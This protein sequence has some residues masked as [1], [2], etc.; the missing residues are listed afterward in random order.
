[1]QVDPVERVRSASKR[2]AEPVES[3]TQTVARRATELVVDTVDVNALLDRTDLNR[4]LAQIDVNRLLDRV[5]V[6]RLIERLDI[7]ALLN[8]VDVNG[9]ADRIDVAALVD[10]TELGA[11]VATSSATVFSE[12]IDL[13]RSQAVGLDDF[14]GRLF[15]RLL[16]RGAYHGPPAPPTLAGAAIPQA[17]R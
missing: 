15:S 12:G 9:L 2:L 4:L 14:L 3:V 1:M 13:I 17:G 16:R 8:R 6:E 11:I 7:D 10:R 5:D